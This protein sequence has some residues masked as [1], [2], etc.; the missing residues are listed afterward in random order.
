MLTC[1][2]FLSIVLMCFLLVVDETEGDK[3][4]GGSWS[5]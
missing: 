2:I 3:V 1:L 5:V 4:L